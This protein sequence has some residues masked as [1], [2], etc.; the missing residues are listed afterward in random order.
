MGEFWVLAGVAASVAFVHTL[1]GPDHYL[2]FVAMA[3]AGDW[4]RRRTLWITV[5]CGLGHVASSILLAALGVLAFRGVDSLLQLEDA[6]GNLAAWGL[7]LFGMLYA[8]WGLRRARRGHP[9]EHHHVHADGTVHAHPHRHEGGHL[10]AHGTRRLTPWVLFLIFALGPCEP[11]IPMLMYAS[12]EAGSLA[13]LGVAAIFSLVTV[14]TMAVVVLLALAGAQRLQ[15]PGMERYAHVFA[16]M[17]V[18]A[19]G[20]AIRFLGL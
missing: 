1:S 3:R 19:C 7:I 6:R 17:A 11:L 14:A 13:A 4:S 8:A 20:L 12:T 5:C 2:P 15:F 10:H 18:M 16:G 9:H